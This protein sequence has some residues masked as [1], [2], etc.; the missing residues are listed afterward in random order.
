MCVEVALQRAH[1]NTKACYK[2]RGAWII[3]K[4]T[5]VMYRP[6]YLK[7]LEL[8][9]IQSQR[10]EGWFLESS[11]KLCIFI[12]IKEFVEV[13][14]SFESKSSS[15]V[16][17]NLKFQAI[18]SAPLCIRTTFAFVSCIHYSFVANFKKEGR[19]RLWEMPWPGNKNTSFT[20]PHS[21][22]NFWCQVK[23]LLKVIDNNL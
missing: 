8:Q 10:T 20:Y 23:E 4:S 14:I 2:R 16:A 17:L 3:C 11:N 13:C 9:P 18:Y 21:V 12:K 22:K 1:L 19:L 7:Q 15:F 5:V 6:L